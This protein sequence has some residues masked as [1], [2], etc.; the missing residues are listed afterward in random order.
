[1]FLVQRTSLLSRVGR[2]IEVRIVILEGENPKVILRALIG[3][4]W[5]LDR[6]WPGPCETGEE[7][8]Q[9][10]VAVQCR[11]HTGH[12]R[13]REVVNLDYL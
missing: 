3:G 8:F 7:K 12:N 5:A 4:N 9:V 2:S 13:A 1:M 10:E 6:V 11:E